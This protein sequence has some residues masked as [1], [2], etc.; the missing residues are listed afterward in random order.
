MKKSV[1]VT[2]VAGSGKTT[3]CKALSDL[4]YNSYDIESIPGLFSLIDEETG[5]PMIKHDGSNP[6]LV[7]KGD[8]NCDKDKMQKLIDDET[9]D[10]TFYCGAASNI[11]DIRS[12][13]DAVVILRVSDK[14][15][16]ERLSSRP[17]GQFGHTSEIREWVLSWK[18]EIEEEWINAGGITVSAEEIP[19]EVAR[20]IVDAVSTASFSRH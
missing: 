1:L 5:E 15:T 20:A 12:L 7:I 11:K 3:A 17:D 6:E 14:T 2:A 10:I 18:H 13:F 4:G 19:A 9:A 16:V 8:W